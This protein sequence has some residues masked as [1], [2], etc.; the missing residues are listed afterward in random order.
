VREVRL[1]LH[2]KPAPVDLFKTSHTPRKDDLHD[3]GL[4]MTRC[5][6]AA[7]LCGIVDDVTSL[8]VIRAWIHPL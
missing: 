1:D 7:D 5:D 3:D 2:G 6:Q 4:P 8:F